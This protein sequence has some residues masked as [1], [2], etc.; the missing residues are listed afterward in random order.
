[1][2]LVKLSSFNDSIACQVS[3]SGTLDEIILGSGLSG[4]LNHSGG[5]LFSKGTNFK[6]IGK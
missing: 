5:Y 3:D 4:S 2:C 6:E 1:M